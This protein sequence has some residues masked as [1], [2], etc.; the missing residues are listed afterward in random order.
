M[1]IYAR[2]NKGYVLKG[3]VYTSPVEF[4]CQ[5]Q[6]KKK[7][8]KMGKMSVYMNITSFYIIHVIIYYNI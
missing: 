1:C 4:E 7:K 8:H 2:A 6:L 3:S 5:R